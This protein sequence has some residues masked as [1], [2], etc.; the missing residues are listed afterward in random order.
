MASGAWASD[1]DQDRDWDPRLV[2]P[3]AL[4][5]DIPAPE[6][7]SGR[8]HPPLEGVE[9]NVAG[10]VRLDVAYEP[11]T[12]GAGECLVKPDAETVFC[13]DPLS[14]PAA[15][16]EILADGEANYRGTDAILRYDAGRVSQAQVLFPADA[17]VDIAGHIQSRYGPPTEQTRTHARR[18]TGGNL[19]NTIL[20]WKSTDEWGAVTVL[21]VRA[22]DDVRR[23]FVDAQHG[24]IALY[25]AGTEPLFR[26]L[27]MVDLMVLKQRRVGQWP[28]EGSAEG[29]GEETGTR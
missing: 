26:Q 22:F 21:E 24:F 29:L 15:L 20:R 16:A 13:V 18:M 10:A 7:K 23:T 11:E 17:F 14:W 8:P 12:R 5:I 9:F 19:S 25:R 6:P 2:A 1:K 3:D 28:V 4:T 27:S